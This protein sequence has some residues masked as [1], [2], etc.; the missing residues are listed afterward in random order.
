M[1]TVSLNLPTDLYQQLHAEAT[2]AGQPVD[3]LV[4]TWLTE[5]LATA[6]SERSRAIEVLKAAGL[7]AEPSEAMRTRAAQATM[8]LAEV[9]TA[10]DRVGGKPLSEVVIEQRGLV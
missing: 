9:Q 7:F 5:R 3:M 6:T 4:T 1:T 2:R 10:L 8:S